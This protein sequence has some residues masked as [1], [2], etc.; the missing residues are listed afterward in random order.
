MR[1]RCRIQ[2]LKTAIFHQVHP[3]LTEDCV[4]VAVLLLESL[5]TLRL[6]SPHGS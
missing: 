4:A 2:D 3:G 5:F 1:Q 6:G